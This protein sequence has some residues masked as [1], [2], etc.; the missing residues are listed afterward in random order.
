[1]GT[2]IFVIQRCQLLKEKEKAFLMKEFT[3]EKQTDYSL[4][5]GLLLLY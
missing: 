2:E 3:L 5:Y 4:K 1:M